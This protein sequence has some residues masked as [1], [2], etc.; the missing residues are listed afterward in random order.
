MDRRVVNVLNTLPEKNRF[1]RGLRAWAG[2]RQTGCVYERAARAAGKTKYPLHK[3]L[4]LAFDGIFNFSTAPLTLIFVAGLTT[5]LTAALAAGIYLAARLGGFTILGHR[6]Q[7]VPGFT[8]LILT[9]LFFSGVQLISVGI[10]GEYLGRIYQETKMRPTYVIKAV[11]GAL[12]P[13]SV[14]MTVPL[15]NLRR[16][17]E[18]RQI[19]IAK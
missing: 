3:L 16:R 12:A 11:R 1:V 9:L 18:D 15:M 8:T 6:V 5:S 17:S 14:R 7:D 13:A 10:V 19:V 2:F 4:R